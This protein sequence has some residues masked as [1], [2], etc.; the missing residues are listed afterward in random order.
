MFLIN[1]LYNLK[2]PFLLQIENIESPRIRIRNETPEAFEEGNGDD[3]TDASNIVISDTSDDSGIENNDLKIS[4][5]KPCLES[6][7]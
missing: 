2:P 6:H 5:E 4:R 1:N 3:I 7:L